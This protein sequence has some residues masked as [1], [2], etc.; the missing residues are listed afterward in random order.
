MSR[1]TKDDD[2]GP[3]VKVSIDKVQKLGVRT[4]IASLRKLI[5]TV[6]AVGTVQ[7]DERRMA[8]VAPKFEG[9]VETLHVDTHRAGGAPGRAADGDL[10]P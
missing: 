3:T 7:V 4:E 8:L 9:Y 5:H 2:S 6:R 1:S 10:Q